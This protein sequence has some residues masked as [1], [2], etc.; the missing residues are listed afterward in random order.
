[1]TLEDMAS[2]GGSD[3]SF[4]ARDT[5]VLD[6]IGIEGALMHT[7]DEHVVIDSIV[8]RTRLFMRLFQTLR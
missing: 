7:H 4:V 2:G 8:P 5:A 3:A 6:G 1:I